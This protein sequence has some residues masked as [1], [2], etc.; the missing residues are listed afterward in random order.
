MNRTQLFI[1]LVALITNACSVAASVQVWSGT[2]VPVT[3]SVIPYTPAA[4]CTGTF[5]PHPMTHTTTVQTP[6]RLFASNGSGVATGDVNNDGQPDIV[7]ANISGAATLAINTG[8]FRFLEQPLD[9]PNARAV[10]IVD[11]NGDGSADISATHQGAGISV[12]LNNNTPNNPSFRRLQATF[13]SARTYS[14]LWHDFN[15]DH[16]LDLV[17]GSY[18][19]EAPRGGSQSVFD[20]QANGVTLHTQTPD[21]GFTQIRLSDHANALSISALDIDG[22]GRDDIVVGNDFD[23]RDM[24]WLHHGTNWV[25]VQPFVS[26]P[27]STMSY[28]LAD[29]DRDGAPE[30]LAADMNP[31]DTSVQTLAQWLPV[32]SRMTQYHPADDPQLMENAILQRGADNRWHN[33]SR[34]VAATSTGWSWS[35]RFGDL[36]NDGHLDLYAV[37]GM[38]A[39]ELFPFLPDHALIE[40]N[41]ALRYDGRRYAPAPQWNLDAIASGRGMAMTDLNADGQLDI[42]VNNLQAPSV[43][44]QNALCAGAAL[45]VSLRQAGANPQAIGAQLRLTSGDITRWGTITTTRGYL[46]G[47]LPAVHFGLGA[48]APTLLAVRWPDGAL[49]TIDTL[50]R[51][52]HIVIERSAP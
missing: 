49:S 24:V 29:L 15:D 26:T 23:T 40:R 33:L 4:P 43:I 38:I 48:D 19:A 28:D 20:A 42:V 5:I 18:D 12:L 34:T 2:S 37:N 10:Q 46:S 6:V 16:L 41:Q 1:P 47:D 36:D 52:G 35:T 8:N 27:H 45:T 9:L 7:L 13:G 25:P 30:L 44:Y 14:M 17:T 32:T 11:V 50:P 51:A 21:G 3:S 22:D 39:Q 31:Y